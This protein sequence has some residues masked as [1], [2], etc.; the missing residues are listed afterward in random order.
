L[1]RTIAAA[2]AILISAAVARGQGAAARPEATLAIKAGR[3]YPAAKDQPAVIEDG[4]VVIREGRIVAVGRDITVPPDVRI[5]ELPDAVIMPGLVAAVS[6]LGLARVPD[7][8]IGAGYRASDTF[9]RF[10]D[11]RRTLASGVTTVHVEP[12]W[13][14]L[15]SGQGAVVRLGGRAGARILVPAADLTINLG[16]RAW[17]PPPLVEE[18]IPPSADQR[19]MPPK[20]QRPTSRLGQ[21]LALKEAIEGALSERSPKFD[22]HSLALGEAWKAGIPVRVQADRAADILGAVSFLANSKRRG[23]V[24]GGAEAPAI[25]EQIAEADVP[26]VYLLDGPLLAPGANLGNDPR[27]ID[28]DPRA[29]ARLKAARLAIALKPGRPVSGLRLAAAEARASDLPDQTLIEAVTRIPAE[30]LG[31]G[32]RIGSLEPGKDADLLVLTG[33]PLETSTHVL[34]VYIAGRLAYEAPETDAVVVRADTLWLGPDQWLED[35]SILIEK[36]RIT[37]VGKAVPHPPGAPLI[38]GGPGSFAT[39]GL[40]DAFGHLG[41]AGDDSTVGAELS[42]TGL[43]GAADLSERRVAEAGVT[44]VML[45]PYKTASAGSRISAVKTAGDERSRRVV[46]DAAATL[47]DVSD[48]DYAAVSDRIKPRMEAGKKYLETW[49]KFRKDLAEWEKRRAEG[50]PIE[51]APAPKPAEEAGAPRQEDPITGTWRIKI[52]GGPIPPEDPRSE[53]KVA[54]KLTGT[55]FEGRVVEPSLTIMVKIVGTLDGKRISGQIEVDTRGL[56]Y[57]TFQGEIDRE[58]HATGT[59]TLQGLTINFEMWRIDKA[60]VEFRVEARRRATVG[61]DGRPLPPKVD[62]S[63]EPIRAVLEKRAAAVVTVSTPAQIDA[64]LDLLADQYDV[65]VVLRNAEGFAP[66]VERL[67][68]KSVGVIVPAQV[69][70][71]EEKGW[72]VPADELARAGVRFALQ[73]NAEDAARTLPLVALQAVERGLSPEAALAAFTVDAAKMFKL[74]DRLGLLAPGREGDVVIFSGHPFQA[75]STVRRVI[76]GGE[77]VEEVDDEP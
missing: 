21:F 42:L 35:G 5:L 6:D 40:I 57:P 33:D 22:Y 25:V 15:V 1:A 64:V 14:R 44:T 70:R 37:S 43:I 38:R 69:A 17:G 34:R 2:M 63:L 55:Q 36:G 12:G 56:G 62:E 71:R 47:F 3:V 54:L 45:A 73:S 9:D 67:K 23:Y 74:D 68:S 28:P 26:L 75:G 24:V 7:E 10:A 50:T 8:S 29:L 51:A 48:L 27:A 39:P 20:A 49:E 30:I 77:E 13:N 58:D 52:S 60:E 76:V 19:I 41:L 31:V 61:K 65:P 32:D 66:H 59:V 18:L 4:T 46:A 16:E 72:E 11:Y 53:A